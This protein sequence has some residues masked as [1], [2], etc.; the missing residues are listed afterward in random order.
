MQMKMIHQIA[1]FLSQA[2]RIVL[3]HKELEGHVS[4][5]EQHIKKLEKIILVRL[6]Y[7]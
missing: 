5:V 6:Y 3:E 1:E 2:K 7:I 4:T